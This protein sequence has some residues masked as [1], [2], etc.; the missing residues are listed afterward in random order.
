MLQVA[1]LISDV[2]HAPADEANIASVRRGVEALTSRF[3]LY[4]WKLAPVAV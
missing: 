4:D 1:K 2:L 3:P